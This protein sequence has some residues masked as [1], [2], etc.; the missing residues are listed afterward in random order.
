MSNPSALAGRRVVVTRPRSQADSLARGLKGLGATPIRL[1]SIHIERANH[2][3][4]LREAIERLSE[5]TW[6]IF[7]SP[8][9]VQLLWEH[10]EAA[11]MSR[12]DFSNCSIA[13]IGPATAEA[14]QGKAIQ[15]DFMPQQ[16]VG[17]SLA[18]EIP[19]V[20]GHRVLLPL[21]ADARPQLPEML[22]R[23]GAEVDEFAIYRAMEA[24]PDEGALAELAYGVDAITFTSPSTVE[25]FIN[26]ANSAGL[27]PF[28]GAD[29]AL[30]ACIGPVTA[31]AAELSGLRPAIVA[32][33]YTVSGLLE[34]LVGFYEGYGVHEQSA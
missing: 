17:E 30:V 6:V 3:D 33:D 20:E 27:K 22:R 1:A 14:L 4:G 9:G 18:E 2:V 21:A 5:Y 10:V 31:K 11:G 29:P 13:A 23:R 7:T 12:R 16:H 32:Q 8:N 24:K 15:V 19:N 28:E 26:I 25:N 34:A